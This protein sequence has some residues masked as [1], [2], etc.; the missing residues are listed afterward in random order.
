VECSD[1]VAFS[2]GFGEEIGRIVGRQDILEAD[3]FVLEQ[4]PNKMEPQVH[5]FGT[6]TVLTYLTVSQVNSPLIVKFND[7]QGDRVAG[8]DLFAEINEPRGFLPSIRQGLIL[9]LCGG[10]RDS[11]LFR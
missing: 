10:Q 7:C 9:C 11:A 8:E 3:D 1:D 5:M 4:V 2:D 6:K